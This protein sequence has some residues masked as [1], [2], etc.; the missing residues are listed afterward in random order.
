M[1]REIYGRN[2]SAFD[3]EPIG[4]GPF[5]ADVTFQ[6]L[7]GIGIASG[8]RSAASYHVDHQHLATGRGG[9]A[10]LVQAGGT[11]TTT[12]FG[13][14]LITGPGSAVVL[15]G[16]DPSVRA[17]HGDGKFVTIALSRPEIAELVPDVNAAFAS[18][19]PAENDALRLLLHYVDALH[20]NAL[21]APAIA[22][23]AA[24]HMLDL[25][26]LALGAKGDAAEVA[27]LRG[28][29]AAR[30]EAIKAYI[31]D[32]I[33]DPE[34]SAASV[35]ARLGVTSRYVH[36]LFEREGKTFSEFVLLRRLERARQ[37]LGD[38]R[39]AEQK[40]SAIALDCG[41]RDIS[42]FNR[43]FRRAFGMTPSDVRPPSL[44]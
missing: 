13:R 44:R 35:A 32:K 15:S 1:W 6:S 10:L 36:R 33:G 4:D 40:I 19:I 39:F 7:P 12:Q 26:A 16:T 5:F 21:G 8:S 9:V 42:Y 43:T 37:M 27:Q 31:R 20:R 41:F 22:E 17:V 38:A 30:L 28:L 2:I 25:A 23:V 11:S 18:M 3:I 29:A 14:E 34:L 24:R